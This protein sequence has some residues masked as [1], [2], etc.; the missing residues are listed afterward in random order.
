MLRFSSSQI[1]LV[2]TGFSDLSC[3][4]WFWNKL[5]GRWVLWLCF[6]LTVF[7]GMALFI[8]IQLRI[9]LLTELVGIGA[10]MGYFFRG[11]NGGISIYLLKCFLLEVIPDL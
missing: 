2:K 10:S 7:G 11:W 6:C 1:W 5:F 8:P 4:Q 9:I 3:S